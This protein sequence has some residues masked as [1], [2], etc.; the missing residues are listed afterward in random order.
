MRSIGDLR[1]KI[2]RAPNEI[3]SSEFAPKIGHNPDEGLASV[4]GEQQ[5]EVEISAS[6]EAD[7]DIN[8]ERVYEILRFLIVPGLFMGS[9][10]ILKIPLPK[11]VL[12]GVAGAILGMIILRANKSPEIILAVALLYMPFA[13]LYAVSI[14][15]LV[16]GTNIFIALC[17]FFAYKSSRE[18]GT[19]FMPALRGRN[20]VLW[21]WALSCGSVVTLVL[22][23]GALSWVIAN[24]LSQAT[25]WIA[26]AG[27]YIAA[28]GLVRTPGQAKRM[29][30]YSM[31][32]TLL[33]VALGTMEWIDKRGNSSIEKS[34]VGGTFEQPND[35]GG[36]LAFTMLPI[37]A[38]LMFNMSKPKAWI[39]SPYLLVSMKVLIATFS[40]GAYVALAFGGMLLSYLRGVR[41]LLFWGCL[42]IG[43]LAAFPSL[44]PASIMARL[45]Q[46]TEAQSATPGQLDKS[47]EI[48]FILWDAAGDMIAESPIIGKGFKAFPYL[49]SQYTRIQVEESDPHSMYLYVGSQMG[50]PALI[51]FLS[52][53]AWFLWMGF[54]I[55]RRSDQQFERVLGA[56]A[57]S[58]VACLALINVFGSRMVNL[59]FT[60]YFYSYLVIMQ[61]LYTHLQKVEGRRTDDLDQAELEL[62]PTR[63]A[64][65]LVGM[66]SSPDVLK[67]R[68]GRQAVVRK[69]VAKVGKDEND[70]NDIKVGRDAVGGGRKGNTE[71]KI[72]YDP[73]KAAREHGEVE[74]DKPKAAPKRLQHRRR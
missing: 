1:P 21:W 2:G 26:Q 61:V 28:I 37:I 17:L 23:P 5:Y 51:L 8:L 12:Y 27:F 62:R 68:L 45:N 35:F 72:G 39:L 65:K 54:Q 44:I 53:K 50:L 60:A 43:M 4:G 42:S 69:I 14:A 19:P 36:F 47:S 56:A 13:K 24:E 18:S 63:N 10:I 3:D 30:I 38:L 71:V 64:V 48:R 52:I 59:E 31:I 7:E 6:A 57:A 29:A 49:K 15:P 32:G 40:R 66:T 58:M 73:L 11:I 34:R 67:V 55:Y 74:D 20:M 22:T 25:A 33:V 41:F 9:I 16:N 46:T 70:G